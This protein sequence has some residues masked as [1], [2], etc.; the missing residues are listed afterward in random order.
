MTSPPRGFVCDASALLAIT[1][2]EPGSDRALAILP[3]A[4]V[5]TV[6]WSETLQKCAR[7]NVDHHAVADGFLNGG[8]QIVE[9]TQADAELA[10]TFWP[11]TRDLGLSLADRA[12]LALAQRLNAT[13]ATAD[14]ALASLA[15]GR[16]VEF[17]RPTAD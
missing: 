5:S 13:L 10:A 6:N 7:R 1:F 17:L 14:R 16:D 12:C 11:E 4:R 15:P 3:G 2:S 8:L 9:F